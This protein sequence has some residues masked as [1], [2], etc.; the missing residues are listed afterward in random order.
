M[1]EFFSVNCPT[2]HKHAYVNN[3][4]EI[5]L[6]HSEVATEFDMSGRAVWRILACYKEKGNDRLFSSHVSKEKY[7]E[8]VQ[9]IWKEIWR[10]EQDRVWEKLLKISRIVFKLLSTQSHSKPFDKPF[11][12]IFV[13]ITDIQ[14]PSQNCWKNI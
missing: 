2:I 8:R 7:S 6:I 1:P 11:I 5:N 9:D 4:A 14:N 10:K 12:M 3:N 13:Y